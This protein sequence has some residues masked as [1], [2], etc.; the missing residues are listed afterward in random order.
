MISLRK[1]TGGV[2][3]GWVSTFLSIAIGLFMSPFLI[4]HLGEAG[5]GVWV[6]VQS[7]VSYMYF[8]DLGM[9][10]TVVRFSAKAQARGDDAEV[11][12]VVSAALVIR[13]ATAAVI[14]L[15][16]LGLTLALPHL[17][18]IPAEYLTTAR[19]ALLLSALT[20]SSTLVFSVFSAVL[21]GLGRFDLLGLLELA[22][23]ICTS[24]GLVPVILH[25][26][27]LIGMAAWQ[28]LVVLSINIA[29]A[30]VCYK[31]Y[32]KLRVRFGRPK[33]ELLRSLWN[34]GFYVLIA[35]GA[36]QLILYSDNVVVGAF[37]AAAAVSYYAVAGKMIEYTRQVAFSVLK[38]FMPMA[39]VYGAQNNFD[40]LRTLHIRGSQ[41]VL[42]VTF[43]ILIT[44]FLRGDTVLR[45]WIGAHFS[46]EATRILQILALAA[47]AMLANSTV[48]GIG[49]ALDRQR[50]LAV[51][52][53]VEGVANLV[54]SILLV[55]RFGV[56]GVAFG[57]L[58]PTL[59]ISIFFW[60][61][62]VTRLLDM[63]LWQ[64]LREGWLRPVLA[65]LPFLLVTLWAE[66]HWVPRHLLTFVLQTLVLLPAVALGG[67][68]LFQRDIPKLIQAIRSRRNP[69]PTLQPNVPQAVTELT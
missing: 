52:A 8:M 9:R 65:L 14:L 21:S 58:L 41:G 69:P 64:Y 2:L 28:F 59:C 7:T 57:T 22:Q 35:N 43:P 6:L 51:V 31:T 18:A 47:A 62:Y 26:Y 23:V 40:R 4:H 54:L 67:G 17:F 1:L 38:F 30:I 49:L 10:T 15:I 19:V 34:L 53:G 20:L 5:Y 44:L 3:I 37:V 60:P 50:L 45:L 36:G 12:Q 68:L 13:L 48:N 32:P 63:P 27:G 42:L 29:T 24:L 33:P 16:A 56:V 39:S 55:H 25:G 61:Q 46:G 11:S 66:H